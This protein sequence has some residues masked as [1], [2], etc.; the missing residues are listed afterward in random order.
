MEQ[1]FQ[2]G[3]QIIR[4]GQFTNGN[5]DTQLKMMSGKRKRELLFKKIKPNH[6]LS[7]RVSQ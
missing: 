4:R 3:T 6:L 5:M 1:K 2:E 7:L